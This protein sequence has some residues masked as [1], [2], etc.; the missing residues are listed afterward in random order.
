MNKFEKISSMIDTE[1]KNDSHRKAIARKALNFTKA[2]YDDYSKN[3]E[4]KP[5][6]EQKR[7]CQVFVMAKMK[8]EKFGFVG[9]IIG[10][11]LFQLIVQVIVKWIMQNFF[12]QD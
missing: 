12:K 4:T 1:F 10:A 7:E 6:E 8:E 5:L 11:I 9:T 3:G 2:W